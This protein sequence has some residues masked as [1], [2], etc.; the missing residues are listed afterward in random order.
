M[1]G[2][3]RINRAALNGR[4]AFCGAAFLMGI[5]LALVAERVGAPDAAV[6]AF[7]GLFALPGLALIGLLARSSSLAHFFAANR[8]IPEAYGGLGF[9]GVASGLAL[10]LL[11]RPGAAP[12][13]P[14]AGAALGIGL[15][16]LLVGPLVRRANASG[17]GD[18]FALRLSG[19]GARWP[20]GVVLLAI[21]ALT[22]IAGYEAALDA[23]AERQILS[24]ASG[25]VVVG[26]ALALSVAPGGLASVVW[27]AA[28]CAGALLLAL[29]LPIAAQVF[30]A[31]GD[32]LAWLGAG[33]YGG[34][35]PTS[36]SAPPIVI[37]A[38][39]IGVGALAVWPQAGVAAQNSPRA[40]RAGAA[41]VL[42]AAAA[43]AGAL[44]DAVGI[45]GVPGPAARGVAGGVL[46]LAGI[47]LAASG[48]FAAIRA[49]AAPAPV[50]P[51]APR[52]LASQRLARARG[53]ALI[54]VGLGGALLRWRALDPGDAILAAVV[55]SLAFVAPPI[56]LAFS[57]RATGAHALAAFLVSFA[58]LAGLVAWGGLPTAPESWLADALVAAALGFCAGWAASLFAAP[59]AP[60][61]PDA[62]RDSYFE[63]PD[64]PRF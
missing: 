22:A 45:G 28:A 30:A 27:S 13:L 40:L 20:L 17:L 33:A 3:G 52:A 29:A 41:G 48:L 62:T 7:A 25:I 15:G 64:G 26:A 59:P 8:A 53:A 37:L 31:P 23:L 44:V 34:F 11:A 50:R 2:P 57:A 10:C 6:R 38:S 54:L 19:A 42:L 5:G 21:G 46:A 12:Q 1:Q 56:G 24:R 18:F 39:A 51:G 60:P 32:P 9:A 61:S 49:L 43:A 58:A 36:L 14:L 16:G 63:L 55:L 35:A 4:A 47:A